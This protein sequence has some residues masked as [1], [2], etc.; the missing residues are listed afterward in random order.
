MYSLL[1]VL[2]YLAAIGIPAYL[3]YRFGTWA[4]Y[5]HLLAIAASLAIGM[6]PIPSNLQTRGFDLLFGF[7]FVAPLFWG[8][9]GLIVYRPHRPHHE[10]HA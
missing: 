3:L 7:S 2:V 1:A 5:W 9:G 10:K 6:T 4:W 8:A